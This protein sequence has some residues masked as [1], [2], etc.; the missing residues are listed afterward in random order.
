MRYLK[1]YNNWRSN[2][3]W[4]RLMW[5]L[6]SSLFVLFSIFAFWIKV[7]LNSNI[8]EINLIYH[9]LY[10]FKQRFDNSLSTPPLFGYFWP[11]VHNIVFKRTNNCVTFGTYKLL[12]Y[13]FRYWKLYFPGQFLPSGSFDNVAKILPLEKIFRFRVRAFCLLFRLL[14]SREKSRTERCSAPLKF[15]FDKISKP[16]KTRTYHDQKK[17]LYKKA[18]R[19]SVHFDWF[20]LFHFFCLDEKLFAI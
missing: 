15:F 12:K 9:I 8:S 1:I 17:I 10:L 6:Y 19:A 2:N 16:K 18:L 14:N 13:H 5:P 4:F 3:K 11:L 20:A 7:A